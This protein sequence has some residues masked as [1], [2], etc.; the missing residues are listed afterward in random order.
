MKKLLLMSVFGLLMTVA[1]STQSVSLITLV[2]PAYAADDDNEPNSSSD[3]NDEVSDNDNE[4]NSNSDSDDD[5]DNVTPI[6]FS[7]PEGVTTCYR[8]DGSE[9]TDVN[10]FSATAAGND[11]YN[12]DEDDEDY[13]SDDDSDNLATYANPRH[14]RSF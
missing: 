12:E 13:A 11:E 1:F 8:A 9:Y 10:N 14:Y 3:D 6:A 5:S 2:A 7:C 4:S